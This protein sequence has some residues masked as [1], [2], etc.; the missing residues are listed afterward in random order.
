MI[1]F[2]AIVIISF[3]CFLAHIT[4]SYFD[5]KDFSQCDFH[6]YDA[7]VPSIDGFNIRRITKDESFCLPSPTGSRTQ[8]HLSTLLVQPQSPESNPY[9]TFESF[10]HNHA[11]W[12][13]ARLKEGSTIW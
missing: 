13:E 6:K 10:F 7:E 11:Q 1:T 9:D 8:V 3:G 4:P 2:V 5:P 12:M